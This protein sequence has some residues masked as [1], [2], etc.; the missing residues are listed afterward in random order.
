[1]ASTGLDY[2]KGVHNNLV[3]GNLFKDIGGTALL[4][5]VY[6]D[7][8]HEIHLPYDP[9]DEREVCDGILISNNLIT[10]ATNEDWSCGV[11]LVIPAIV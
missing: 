5:G 8:G 9:K 10:N 7:A 1:L 4:A 3:K 2:H 11:V 6:S